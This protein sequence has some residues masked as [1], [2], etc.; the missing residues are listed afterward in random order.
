MTIPPG[1]P[2]CA[3][4]TDLVAVVGFDLDMTLVDSR[5]GIASTLT[6]LATETGVHLDVDVIVGRLGARLEDELACWYPR[7][8]VPVV[9]DRYRALYAD[10]GVPG[11]VL[12]PGA[13]D[14]VAAARADGGRAVVITAKYEP[15][16]RACL[17]HV[18]LDVDAVVGWRWGPTKGAALAEHGAAVYVADT[19]D[20]VVGA[21]DAPALAVAVATGPHDAATLRA[22]GADVV[23]ASLIEFPAWFA[24]WA[25]G[26]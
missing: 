1:A 8:A 4:Q 10:L 2:R 6:A 26:R 17:R 11:T 12:L 13:A 9:A 19:P 21:H 18:G 23:L 15:N 14:A 20:D 25:A 22:A 7:D 5:P 24:A 3:G 16:A